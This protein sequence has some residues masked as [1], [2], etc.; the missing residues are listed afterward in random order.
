MLIA[1][2]F[3]LFPV[4]WVI[5]TSFKNN[6]DATAPANQA[7]DFT[8]TLDNF[9]GVLASSVFQAALQTSLVVTVTTTLAVVVVALLGGYAFARLRVPGRRVLVAVMVLVQVIPGIVLLIP[10]F[11]IVSQAR[12]YDQ[13][14]SLIIVLTGLLTPFATWLMLAFIRSFPEE[15]EEAA[16]IDGANR[17]Q[18]FRHVLIPM[19]APGLVTAAIFTAIAAWN[20]FLIPVI[21]GQSRAQTLTVYVAGF[22]TQQE[23]KWAELCATAVIILAPIVLFTLVMQRPLVKGITA[24]SLKS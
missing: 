10:L 2:L 15:I 5:L 14:I 6:A 11:R 9:Q 1:V 21:L 20:S 19:V 7:F 17:F 4:F 13:W 8:P 24:G 18:M 16:M 3:A 23:I 22:V 12:L